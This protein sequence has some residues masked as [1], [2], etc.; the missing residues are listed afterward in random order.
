MRQCLG[1][2][3]GFCG[4][5]AQ[6]HLHRC[7][8]L[9]QCHTHCSDQK[10]RVHLRFA[11][12]NARGDGQRKPDHLAA[13]RS[14]ETD[15]ARRANLVRPSCAACS[16]RFLSIS[17]KTAH[18]FICC[19]FASLPDSLLT[20][21]L[22]TLPR[23]FNRPISPAGLSRYLTP[24]RSS[25]QPSRSTAR[26]AMLRRLRGYL[27][28][29][30]EAAWCWPDTERLQLELLFRFR[31]LSIVGSMFGSGEHLIAC[32]EFENDLALR[33]KTPSEI[34]DLL[35][36]LRHFA[37][38]HRA[39][40]LHVFLQHLD[41]ARTHGLEDGGT[42]LFVGSAQRHGQLLL[43]HTGDN[44]ANGC[45]WNRDKIFKR[46]HQVAN[47]EG[48]LRLSFFNYLENAL[49]L[50]GIQSVHQIGYRFESR[51]AFPAGVSHG[52]EAPVQNMSH[53]LRHFRRELPH[54]GQALN[55][56]YLVL[57]AQIA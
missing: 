15:L 7:R 45:R 18:L 40:N 11:S 53:L 26:A 42:Q 57:F 28:R 38:A 27:P 23:F 16:I 20:S 14:A 10:Q 29:A 12:E 56:N 9:P 30:S 36:C 51:I 54:L 32:F 41:R 44:L 24:H 50:L 35:L 8:K 21:S 22:E 34:Q 1:P 49:R 37:R 46:E 25:S 2:E 31:K 17:C 13:P 19:R 5:N 52:F 3:T 39:E 6:P 48:Q 4:R 55:G 33:L 47:A 43:V